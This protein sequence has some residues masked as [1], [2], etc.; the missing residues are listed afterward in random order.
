[1]V[2]TTPKM[3]STRTMSL[4]EALTIID[5]ALRMMKNSMRRSP[6]GRMKRWMRNAPGR[7]IE[8]TSGIV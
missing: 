3:K 6:T 7:L 5:M 2:T 4:A 8:S 1:M